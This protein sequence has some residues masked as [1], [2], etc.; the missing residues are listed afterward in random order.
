MTMT[1]TMTPIT[2]MLNSRKV[3]QR[4]SEEEIEALLNAIEANA[5]IEHH[6]AQAPQSAG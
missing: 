3:N 2:I 4:T 6:E 1:M 5:Q